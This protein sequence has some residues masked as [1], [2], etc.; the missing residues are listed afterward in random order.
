[1]ICAGEEVDFEEDVY[2]AEVDSYAWNFEGGQ[3]STSTAENPSVTYN[4]PGV[5]D[6]SLT[7]ANDVGQ[8]THTEEDMVIVSPISAQHSNNWG[9]VHSFW[10]EDNFLEDF[11]VFNHDNAV[12]KWEWYEGT[13]GGQSVR[14][15]NRNNN[16]GEVDELISPS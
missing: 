8:D 5:Y 7:A 1:M 4:T 11:V 9:Y 13:N 2:N 15:F 6:V 16:S 12:N 14:M 3:P 10:L